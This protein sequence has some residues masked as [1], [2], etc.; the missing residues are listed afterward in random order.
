MN[1]RNIIFVDDP[2]EQKLVRMRDEIIRNAEREEEEEKR[3]RVEQG[4]ATARSL[5]SPIQ[6][7]KDEKEVAIVNAY[8]VLCDDYQ[9]KRSLDETPVLIAYQGQIYYDESGKPQ[10]AADSFEGARQSFPRYDG[11][12]G[13]TGFAA[14]E[15]RNSSVPTATDLL[16]CLLKK[17][18]LKR[19]GDAI[20]RFDGAR[21]KRLDDNGVQTLISAVLSDEIKISGAA[22]QISN[23]YTLLKAE[24]T[25][26]GRPIDPST[27][28][29]IAVDNGLL[30]RRNSV[31]RTADSDLFITTKV[32]VCWRPYSS[33]PLFERFLFD[34]AN[35]DP[36]LI[37]RLWE[38][39]DFVLVPNRIKRIALLQGVGDSG[40]TLLCSLLE[41]FF[42][43]NE[44][45]HRDIHRAGDRFALSD[46]VDKRLNI[47]A[48]LPAGGLSRNAVAVLKQISG[49]D[50]VQTEEKYHNPRSVKL[51]CKLVIVTNHSLS[52]QN[53]D[54]AFANRILLLPFMHKIPPEQQD[55]MLLEKL[56]QEK[57]GIFVKAIQ[58]FN[59]LEARNFIFSGDTEYSFEKQVISS[60][61][62]EADIIQRFV[63]N[64]CEFSNGFTPTALLHNSYLAF[65]VANGYPA[66]NDKVAF[67]RQLALTCGNRI[68][69][70]KQRVGGEAT[71]GYEGIV[72]KGGM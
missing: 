41:S 66:I 7:F 60:I 5:T 39:V 35:G 45:S 12:Y 1:D 43:D 10:S 25:I 71:N 49:N 58:V 18:K 46:F 23:V 6:F 27:S 56:M 54:Q 67:S 63:L 15:K 14:T 52:L 3:R 47:S 26:L 65:C 36:K 59:Q 48:D 64:S 16:S 53:Y 69:R 11:T 55:H 24:S 44:V 29:F 62:I 37:N 4:D 22:N 38:F 31:Y 42:E 50:T 32:K 9:K 68:M 13:Y 21:Y 19:D 40:K 72:L 8:D 2:D 70:K 33:C 17:V 51:I 30:D 57:E 61:P 28:P 20:Y 34:C